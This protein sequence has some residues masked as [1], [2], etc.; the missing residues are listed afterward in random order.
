MK[1]KA[2]HE[3]LVRLARFHIALVGLLSLNVPPPATVAISSFVVANNDFLG[4][5]LWVPV[6]C[7]LNFPL[8]KYLT[9]VSSGGGKQCLT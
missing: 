6:D 3:A 4:T 2:T 5:A 8:T 1:N 7:P 9:R